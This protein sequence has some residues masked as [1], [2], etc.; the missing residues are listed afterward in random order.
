MFVGQE[1]TQ[2][3]L[4]SVV[5]RRGRVLEELE[6]EADLAP[7][8][9]DVFHLTGQP[10]AEVYGWILAADQADGQVPADSGPVFGVEANLHAID[11]Q[12]YEF[13]A[14]RLLPVGRR[15]LD[16]DGFGGGERMAVGLSAIFHDSSGGVNMRQSKIHAI[17][18]QGGDLGQVQRIFTVYNKIACFALLLGVTA[19]LAAE[20]PMPIPGAISHDVPL[21]DIKGV[22]LP[23]LSIPE[24][25]APRPVPTSDPVAILPPRRLASPDTP[26]LPA[27]KPMPPLFQLAPVTPS[28]E[29][30]ALDRELEHLHQENAD[31]LRGRRGVVPSE[32][33][34]PK[35]GGNAE[36][37]LQL[38]LRLADKLVLLRKIRAQAKEATPPPAPVVEPVPAPKVAVPPP[39]KEGPPPAPQS[40][41]DRDDAAETLVDAPGLGR[42]LFLSG[43]YAKSLE[44]YRSIEPSEQLPE[45]RLATQYVMACCLRKLGKLDDAAALYREVGNSGGHES[46]VTNAQWHLQ[47]MKGHQELV[48]ELERLRSVR[49]N[50]TRKEPQ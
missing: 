18:T 26:L 34:M 50:L 6:A 40:I 21:P 11:R 25:P 27:P 20:P 8:L 47:T 42:V 38:R 36:T 7:S 23:A 48:A 49:V 41:P 28:R 33:S 3:A 15:D 19:T 39:I 17:G 9:L 16:P 10:Q 1:P 12:I 44:A 46:L 35:A 24:L 32:V 30:E 29:V 13:A 2:P 22:P 5:R 37:S 31:M 45:D 43:A 4:P 14:Q